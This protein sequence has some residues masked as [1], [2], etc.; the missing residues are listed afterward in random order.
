MLLLLLGVTILAGC[1]V[2]NF[3]ELHFPPGRRWLPVLLTKLVQ[4]AVM[5]VLVVRLRP[6]KERTL[7]AMER[8]IWS[9]IP[10][11][12]LGYLALFLANAFLP[13]PMPL[14]PPLAVLSGLGFA[15]LGGTI[16]GWFYVWA[17]FFFSLALLIALFPLYGLALL[18]LGWFVCLATGAVHMRWTR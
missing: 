3:W 4:I 15:T 9:L 1:S 11:Y 13:E 8:Q 7:T 6:T 16:W 10:G 12:Y 5:L 2:S 18:G 14:A 17:L